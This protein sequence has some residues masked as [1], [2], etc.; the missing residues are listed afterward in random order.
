MKFYDFSGE[1]RSPKRVGQEE[2]RV[3]V[4]VGKTRET[5]EAEI[6]VGWSSPRSW[7]G[8]DEDPETSE[9]NIFGPRIGPSQPQV[10]AELHPARKSDSGRIQFVVRGWLGSFR[11]PQRSSCPRPRATCTCIERSFSMFLKGHFKADHYSLCM[12]FNPS[13]CIWAV[14]KLIASDDKS[15]FYE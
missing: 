4:S 12:S 13:C 8:S 14:F 2:T 15:N 11:S 3:D 1:G 6:F 5:V 9:S 7:S 10:Q